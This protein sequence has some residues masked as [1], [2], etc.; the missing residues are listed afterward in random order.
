MDET[1][2]ECSRKIT[3]QSWRMVNEGV[4]QFVGKFGF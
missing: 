1:R 2:T 4:G 3:Q